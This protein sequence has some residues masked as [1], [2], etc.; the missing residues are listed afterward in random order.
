MYIPSCIYIYTYMRVYTHTHTHIQSVDTYC[1]TFLKLGRVQSWHYEKIRIPC[2]KAQQTLDLSTDF[3]CFIFISH[4]CSWPCS[5]QDMGRFPKTCRIPLDMFG[6]LG[7]TSFESSVG[8]VTPCFCWTLIGSFPNQFSP[9]KWPMSSDWGSLLLGYS[10]HFQTYQVVQK[11]R[12]G[13]K[14]KKKHWIR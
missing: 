5:T 14:W 8:L 3:A 4:P 2:L 6:D 10:H 13:S 9:L 12:E 11:A 7:K 1:C